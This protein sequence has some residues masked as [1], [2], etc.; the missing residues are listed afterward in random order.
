MRVL[1]VQKGMLPVVPRRATEALGEGDY[2]EFAE[3]YWKNA[4]RVDTSFD[5]YFMDDEYDLTT[6]FKLAPKNLWSQ[7]Q[8]GE[9]YGSARRLSINLDLL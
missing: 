8:P 4:V 7:F 2:K 1:L 5:E 9:S 6:K 3:T